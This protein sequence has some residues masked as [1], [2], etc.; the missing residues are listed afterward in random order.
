MC[1]IV[2]ILHGVK[3][4]YHLIHYQPQQPTVTTGNPDISYREIFPD[5]RLSSWIYSYWLLAARRELEPMF[6]YRVVA[7]GCMDVIIDLNNPIHNFVIGFFK[8]YSEYPLSGKFRYAGIRFLP[9]GFP[10][11]L[12]IP[13][14]DLLEAFEGFDLVNFKLSAILSRSLHAQM[15]I[16]SLKETLDCILLKWLYQNEPTQDGRFLNAVHIILRN[17]GNVKVQKTLD[18]GASP[19]QLRRIFDHYIGESPKTF[20]QIVRFQYLLSYLLRNG[21]NS[22]GE[23][24][25]LGYFD[26]AHFI[27]DFKNFY[28]ST[29]GSVIH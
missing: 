23:F 9:G 19:R 27:K 14:K 13:A 25:K 11:M 7:D 16:D 10:A 15:D 4:N 6:R 21:T 22:S 28:G 2:I 8:N 1:G 18:V 12:G 29:P 17:N 24:Y 20:S 3:K 26:Q 5:L